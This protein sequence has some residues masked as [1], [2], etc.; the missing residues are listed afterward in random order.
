[1]AERLYKLRS[2]TMGVL[3]E[4]DQRRL[5]VIPANAVVS[6]IDGDLGG[7]GYIK[8]RYGE[9]ELERWSHRIVRHRYR[10]GI[11]R[12]ILQPPDKTL[13]AF[14]KRIDPVKVRHKLRHHRTIHRS[15]YSSNIDLC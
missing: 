2:R 3:A 1:M 7:N 13:A 15:E 9:Q 5:V 12:F 14:G 4:D 6:T 11:I 10:R 8:I